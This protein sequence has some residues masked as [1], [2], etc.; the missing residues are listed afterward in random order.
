MNQ[1]TILGDLDDAR[2][3]TSFTHGPDCARQVTLF[4]AEEAAPSRLSGYD[5]TDAPGIPGFRLGFSHNGTTLLRVSLQTRRAF[6]FYGN[7]RAT[8]GVICLLCCDLRSSGFKVWQAFK[9][10]TRFGAV[11]QDASAALLCDQPLRVDFTIS[12]RSTETIPGA[13]LI[14]RESAVIAED[15]VRFT[16]RIAPK[17]V[18]AMLH[19]GA[20]GVS[21]Y[22]LIC[23]F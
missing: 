11:D 8:G 22:F 13:K 12:S 4:E 6:S 23:G 19:H 10:T 15:I 5:A 3:D 1:G 16:H 17:F 7:D 18:S 14:K 2:L 9:P 20:Q 21:D